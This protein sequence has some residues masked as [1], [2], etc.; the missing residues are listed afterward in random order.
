[1]EVQQ[2]F[3]EL[4]AL[5][6]AHNVEFMIVGG[7]ALA[8]Y[9]APRYTGDIDIYVKPDSIN[10]S[11]VMKALA[12]FGFK[13]AG[14]TASDFD[15]PE[16]V[17]QLGVPPVRIDI[18][19]SLTGITWDDA[20]SGR[21]SGKY[22]DISVYYIGRKEFIANKRAINRKKDLADIEALGGDD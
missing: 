10:A 14:L 19:T 17:V 21:E 11:R 8:F 7:Y 15:K 3:R 9:G 20:F 4:L 12:D 1:M 18:V 13:S 2:D 6:N 5:F 22:A 16:K